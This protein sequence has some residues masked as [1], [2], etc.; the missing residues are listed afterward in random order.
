MKLAFRALAVVMIPATM[1]FSQGLFVYWS[2]NNVFSIL[3][4]LA[5]KNFSVRSMLSIPPMP[6]SIAPVSA[7]PVVEGLTRAQQ[8]LRLSDQLADKSRR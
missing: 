7:I 4:A 8:T 6:V 3:Q 1:H 2:A 5:L